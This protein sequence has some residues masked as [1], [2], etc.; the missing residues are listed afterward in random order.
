MAGSMRTLA[1]PSTRSSVYGFNPVGPNRSA[2]DRRHSTWGHFSFGR[3]G[4]FLAW[5]N[6][7][8][9]WKEGRLAYSYAS[10]SM[11]SFCA[12]FIAG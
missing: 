9:R 1:G 4:T 5:F 12:A 11:G 2:S 8:S 10:A 3:E 6:P 7:E